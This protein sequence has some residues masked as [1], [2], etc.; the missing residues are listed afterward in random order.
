MLLLKYSTSFYS[1]NFNKN[2]NCKIISMETQKP[3]VSVIIPVFR[4]GGGISKCIKSVLGQSLKEIEIIFIDDCG[5]DDAMEKV[6]EA[7]AKDDRIIILTNTENSGSGFSRNRGI[8]VSHGEYLSFIDADDFINNAFLENL[9]QKAKSGNFDIVKGKSIFCLENGTLIHPKI[10]L[11]A[12]T[13][14]WLQQ[15]KPL[16]AVFRYEHWTAIYRRQMLIDSNVRYGL[17]R[18]SQDDTFLL[19]ATLAAKTFCFTENAYYYYCM[20]EN[21]T[22]HRKDIGI[23]KATLDFTHEIFNTIKEKCPTDPYAPQFTVDI[24][25]KFLSCHAYVSKVTGEKDE[26]GVLL[27][28]FR[29]EVMALPFANTLID[30]HTE[31]RAL[32]EYGENLSKTPYK[33]PGED[34]SPEQQLDI[35]NRWCI[36]FIAHPDLDKRYK[37]ALKMVFNNTQ[38]IFGIQTQNLKNEELEAIYASETW[39]I[40]NALVQPLHYAKSIVLKFLHS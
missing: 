33:F 28:K 25:I 16:Y 36:F 15:K 9:Y 6:R 2:F 4:P 24:I 29:H 23:L 10:D 7:A 31:I 18:K 8:E 21:S 35:L 26:A 34:P 5:N 11:N 30:N 1:N 38:K 22:V 27:Q 14:R 40:G 12:K 32:A 13:E 39:K 17:S 3:K 19:R 37:S 20:R